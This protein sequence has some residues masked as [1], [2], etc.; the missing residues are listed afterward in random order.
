MEATWGYAEHLGVTTVEHSPLTAVREEEG[1]VRVEASDG[2]SFL[3]TSGLVLAPGAW[4]SSSAK[5][6][7]GLHIPTRVSAETV[8]YFAPKVKSEG[9][10]AAVDHSYESMPVFCSAHDNG[11]GAFGYYGLPMIDVPGIKAS[12]HYC[13]PTV[14]PRYRPS[15]AGGV[16][17]PQDQTA[18]AMAKAQV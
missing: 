14:D 11:L 6:L 16:E 15:T 12:A 9:G 10:A 8:C 17:G 5:A 4:L 7:F 2:R 13:G 1:G 18:E 3:A